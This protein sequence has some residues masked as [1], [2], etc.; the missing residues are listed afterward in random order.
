MKISIALLLSFTCARAFV[1]PKTT[2]GLATTHKQPCLHPIL[3]RDRALAPRP[4]EVASR[5][6]APV[7]ERETKVSG[8]TVGL[9]VFSLLLFAG[10]VTK[11]QYALNLPCVSGSE[12]CTAKHLL[13]ANFFNDHQLIAFFLVCT[14]TIPFVLFP[15]I[16]RLI[17][18]KGEIIKNDHP[19]FNPFILTLAM[20]CT[21]FGLSLEVGW[22]VWDS[23]YYDNNFHPLNFGFYF[24]LIS[25]FALWADAFKDELKWDIGF[26]LILLA[27]TILY[28]CGM[29]Q[30]EGVQLLSF[31]NLSDAALAK[32]PLYV[33][34][35]VN[36]TVLTLRGREIFG[37]NMYLVA[38]LSVGVNLAFIAALA[39]VAYTEGAELTALNYWYHIG[40]DFLGTEMGVAYFGYL[41]AT[42]EPKSLTK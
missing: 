10:V 22:H 3:A 41:I 37:N 20:A 9:A 17:S 35:T 23:W 42:Y 1:V 8:G 6:V 15:T 32:I 28:P 31:I 25:S 11:T 5:Q 34:M 40:H 24:F 12:V 33:G 38:A 13:F 14:H 36:F 2:R 30:Q 29:F 4:L 21:A 18:E 7:G 19:D 26:G 27:A 16:M 39:G